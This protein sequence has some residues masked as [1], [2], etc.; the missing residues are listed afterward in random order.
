MSHDHFNFSE[1]SDHDMDQ[2]E[3]L[4]ADQS[5]SFMDGDDY[6]DDIV[7][8]GDLLHHG[9]GHSGLD[10]DVS[11]DEDEDEDDNED[12]IEEDD[13][14]EEDEDDE[15]D[16]DDTDDGMEHSAH[17]RAQRV[18]QRSRDMM[19]TLSAALMQSGM[20]SR[21]EPLLETLED[22]SDPTRIM[23][24]LSELSE[25]LLVASEDTF[26]G[27]FPAER[28]VGLLVDILNDPMYE[29][30]PD[31]L[32]SACSNINNLVDA[33]PSAIESI[34]EET[35]VVAVLSSRLV[36]I[37]YIDLAEQAVTTLRKLAQACPSAVL[38][39][40]A[41]TA[42]LEYFDFF[43]SHT[44]QAILNTA[45]LCCRRVKIDDFASAAMLMPKF[46]MFLQYSDSNILEKVVKCIEG[47]VASFNGHQDLTEKLITVDM[48]KQLVVFLKPSVGTSHGIS[49]SALGILSQMVGDSDEIVSSLVLSQD[50]D[51]IG[52]IIYQLLT[53]HQPMFD[54]LDA[55]Q[56]T[57]NAVVQ[58]LMHC[59]SALIER[60]I[61]FICRIFPKPRDLTPTRSFS[62]PFRCRPA[63]LVNEANTDE[64]TIIKEKHR[65]ARESL[66]A[67]NVD[68]D[69]LAHFGRTMCHLLLDI[70]ASSVETKI[71]EGV[72][73]SVLRI[74]SALPGPSLEVLPRMEISSLLS[75]VLSHDAPLQSMAALEIGIELLAKAPSLYRA[76]FFRLGIIER[77]EQLCKDHNGNES[78][79]SGEPIKVSLKSN[80]EPYVKLVAQELVQAYHASDDDHSGFDEAAELMAVLRQIAKGLESGVDPMGS[81]TRL[82][83]VVRNVSSFELVHSGVLKSLMQVLEDPNNH[84][85]FIRSFNDGA[86]V[87]LELLV[88]RLREALSRAESLDVITVSSSSTKN[89]ASLLAKQMKLKL[90][91]TDSFFPS[92]LQTVVLS[93]QAI[94]TFMVVSDFIRNETKLNHLLRES[95][96]SSASARAAE[97]NS[98]DEKISQDETDDD[99]DNE[100]EIDHDEILEPADAYEVNDNMDIDE[101]SVQRKPVASGSNNSKEWYIE[102][103]AN[104]EPVPIDATIFGT[105]YQLCRDD[106]RTM[107]SKTYE[108]QYHKKL[109]T[110]PLRRS[111]RQLEAEAIDPVH[112]TPASFGDNATVKLCLRL[113]TVLSE[114]NDRFMSPLD[115]TK[116]MSSKLTAKLNRQMDEP[117]V[118]A[119]GLIPKWTT[120]ATRLYPFLFSFDCRLN[121]LQL[122]S[123]GYS[124]SMSRWLLTQNNSS[125]PH[126]SSN[127]QES[128]H[129][130]SE[131]LPMGRLLRQKVRISRQHLLQSTIKVMKMYGGS[132]NM[133]EVEF[134]DEVGTGLGPTLEFYTMASHEFAARKL[135][136]WRY[137]ES[138]DRS[139]YGSGISGLL[140]PA[141]MS[142]RQRLESKGR[143]V[144]HLFN[145]LGTFIA[146]A[147]L[148]S[149]TIDVNINPVFFKLARSQS[150]HV[151]SRRENLELLSR[152]DGHLAKSLETLLALAQRDA[153]TAIEDMALEFTLPGYPAIELVPSGSSVAVCNENVSEYVDRIIDFTLGEGI[154]QQIESFKQGFSLV[155]PYSAL[156]AFTPYELSI[157]CG[158]GE[159]DW[160]YDTIFD[161][162]RADHGYTRE[163]KIVQDLVTI[164]SSFDM[165]E[166]RSFLQFMTGSPI[167]PVGG[168]K[169]LNPPFT[170]VWKQSEEPLGRD[171]Y[172]PSVM[173]CANYLKLPNYSTQQVLADRLRT[174]IEEGSGAFHLS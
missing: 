99:D 147:L 169:A 154:A 136:M 39:S 54:K 110:R 116:F 124:R 104:G 128:S 132:P 50:N 165:R 71:R 82:T 81:F 83:S 87:P 166:R 57:D 158:Q 142:A 108:I 74:A 90:S 139:E 86:G 111:V 62:G 170:V 94:A 72:L 49:V 69:N 144:L 45:V 77:A 30:N 156:D 100:E 121:F 14:D 10:E 65:I 127:G 42:A 135:G 123:F 151:N 153:A 58:N 64:A 84:E 7:G 109:G 150:E 68:P 93:V 164:L 174:A 13:D 95:M 60:T 5:M 36:E 88:E 70:Y 117:L 140:F 61:L 12:H 44:Q 112:S 160:S 103:T 51:R 33:L 16:E 8:E 168:F 118:I 106:V 138:E 107:W 53:R 1:G 25:M 43:P 26:I 133:L 78:S 56:K 115:A 23:M 21:V 148:D 97:N 9:R 75:S 40:G 101:E 66:L 19:Y 41:V 59:D 143:K 27:H 22:R 92:S 63:H 134:F 37:Q 119:S 47:V 89:Q 6:D 91:T 73:A 76:T 28:L 102:F 173:T 145:T 113:L 2:D 167:L 126:S 52:D 141:P 105:A 96:R 18:L 161:A 159:E 11:D 35:D 32:L 46:C 55:L 130:H 3:F 31:I 114:L 85:M 67:N 29:D 125:D 4:E 15:D 79:G 120:D 152:V 34:V 24:G 38:E 163:S 157:L 20:M 172:L 48:A 162:L 131:R 146:R 137:T 98:D 80:V 129:G 171:D 149:R 122:T 155:F 17:S